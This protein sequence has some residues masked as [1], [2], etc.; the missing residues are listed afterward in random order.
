MN[1]D[2]DESSFDDANNESGDELDD[3]LRRIFS[4]ENLT[5]PVADNATRSI[6]VGA[7]KLRRRRIVAATTGAAVVIGGAALAGVAFAGIGRQHAVS[8]A[9]PPLVTSTSATG[10]AEPTATSN[11]LPD[12]DIP[13]PTIS[14]TPPTVSSTAQRPRVSTSVPTTNSSTAPAEPI[15]LGPD[16]FRQ[17]KLGMTEQQAQATG[18]LEGNSISTDLVCTQYKFNDNNA[19]QVTVY[20]SRQGGVVAIGGNFGTRTAEGIGIGANT[21][22]LKRAYPNLIQRGNGTYIAKVSGRKKF[23]YQFSISQQK[24]SAITISTTDQN[25]TG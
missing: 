16:G 13:S 10:Y 4:G 18:M 19:S 17:L 8:V 2:N 11:S 3:K 1:G 14:A 25:C 23:Q 7:R 20:I 5:I 6:V 21:G 24:V 22:Q 9:S 15:V 12:I